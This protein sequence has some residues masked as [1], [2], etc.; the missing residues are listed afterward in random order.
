MTIGLAIAIAILALP[1]IAAV[2]SVA[3]LIL[4]GRRDRKAEI[5]ARVAHA[6]EGHRRF[7]AKLERFKRLHGIA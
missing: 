7:V 6:E 5:A 1:F 4:D 2:V 3:S